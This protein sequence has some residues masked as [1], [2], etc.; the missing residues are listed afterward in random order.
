MQIIW[1]LIKLL[2]HKKIINANESS[3]LLRSGMENGA[4]DITKLQNNPETLE[5]TF[6][7]IHETKFD[8]WQKKIIEDSKTVTPETQNAKPPPQNTAPDAHP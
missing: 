1:L 2:E 5:P 4:I 8:D 6:K 3:W 7:F